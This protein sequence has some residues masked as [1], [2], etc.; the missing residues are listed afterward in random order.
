ML[1]QWNTTQ[2]WKGTNYGYAQQH[3]QFT[4][5]VEQKKPDTKSAWFL[6][7]EV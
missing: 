6:L 1:T 5:Y 3:R 4:Y 7:Y 2:Q